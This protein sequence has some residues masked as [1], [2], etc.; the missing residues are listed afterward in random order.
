MSEK[1]SSKFR[2]VL[3]LLCCTQTHAYMHIIMCKII[4]LF[5]FSLCGSGLRTR[6]FNFYRVR[7][8]SLILEFKIYVWYAGYYWFMDSILYMCTLSSFQPFFGISIIIDSCV[9]FP[10]YIYVIMHQLRAMISYH[11]RIW[12]SMYPGIQKSTSLYIHLSTTAINITFF[13]PTIATNQPTN[14]WTNFLQG[15]IPYEK[16]N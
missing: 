8:G 15:T 3:L 10:P 6:A 16:F 2:Y 12:F 1:C 9:L 5:I 13:R 11:G 7:A 14:N 4:L